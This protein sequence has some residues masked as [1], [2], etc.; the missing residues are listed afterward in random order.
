[1][2]HPTAA[3][4]PHALTLHQQSRVLEIGFDD[5]QLFRL[6]FDAARHIRP[7]PRWYMAP[8][9]EVLQT[10]KREVGIVDGSRSATT[11]SSRSS[12]TAATAV[13]TPGRC[14][15]IWHGASRRCG[16]LSD[17]LNAVGVD[18]D[19]PMQSVR[20]RAVPAPPITTEF[21]V[22]PAGHASCIPVLTSLP[23]SDTHFWL[24][25]RRRAEQGTH[26]ARRVLTRSRP[27]T[28]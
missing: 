20:P 26:G 7:L 4:S 21:P 24:Q 12:A 15:T 16:R 10:G 3:P 18:R 25:D 14:C 17:R 6:P 1:M 9:Q 11:P 22:R 28:T 23:M 27:V 19:A 8:G 5:G 13:S 2:T